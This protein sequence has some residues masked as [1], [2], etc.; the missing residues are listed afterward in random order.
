MV[1]SPGA[2]GSAAIKRSGELV[3]LADW[4]RRVFDLY[5]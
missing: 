2:A 3:A 5:H 4:R 1:A